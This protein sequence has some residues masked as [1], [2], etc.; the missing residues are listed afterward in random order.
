MSC[1]ND[2]ANSAALSGIALVVVGMPGIGTFTVK[3]VTLET[4]PP[5]EALKTVTL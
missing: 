3:V 2:L 4:P 1:K 5:G